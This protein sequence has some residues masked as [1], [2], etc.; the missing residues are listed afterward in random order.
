MIEVKNIEKSFRDIK[1]LKDLSFTVEKGIT[2]LIGPNGAGK[3]TTIKIILGL[4]HPT[5]GEVKLF[6]KKFSSKS[7]RDIGVLH[8]KCTF[9]TNKKGIEYLKYMASLK[10]VSE[11]EI[12]E[13]AEL[14]GIDHALERKIGGY[15]A[16]MIQRLGLVDALLGYPK[17]VIL[18]EPTSNLD[19][20]ARIEFLKLIQQFYRDYNVS[21]LIS[22]HILPELEKICDSVII[23]NEGKLLECG[24][25]ADLIKKYFREEYIVYPIMNIK[26]GKIKEHNGVMIVEVENKKEFLDSVNRNYVELLYKK[27]PNLEDI[28]IEVLK[29]SEK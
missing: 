14:C 6:G 4:I 7:L 15:S 13:T 29:C 17:L 1:A 8:E 18:D 25:I 24:K 12:H 3:S 19:P 10:N 16:G 28:F 21:F 26:G 20:L 22:T 2:G 11:K 23:L 9:P 27:D 5:K